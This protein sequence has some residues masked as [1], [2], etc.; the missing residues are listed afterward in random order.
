MKKRAVVAIVNYKGKVLVGRKNDNSK[1]FLAGKWHLP[2]ESVE[3]RESDEEALVR[4]IREEASIDIEVGRYVG[5]DTTPSGKEA[6]WYECSALSDRII[7]GGDL[8]AVAWVPKREVLAFIGKR[9][10][11]WPEEMKKYFE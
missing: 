4:G 8:E 2:A 10:V 11:S 7:P 9:T 3:G 5:K 1:K 6:R